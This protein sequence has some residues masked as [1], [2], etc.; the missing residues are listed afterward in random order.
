MPNS[1]S[2]VTKYLPELDKVYQY[3]S[4]SA[5]L[6]TPAAMVRETGDARTI[7][8]AKMSM[9]GM[10]DYDR[11]AGY[12]SG[13]VTLDWETHTFSQDRARSFEVDAMDDEESFQ[14]SFGMLSGEFI[15]T[16]EV[17]DTDA[18]RFA[19]Y[20]S[21]AITNSNAATADLSTGAGVISALRTAT[22]AMD[23]AEV[24]EEGRILFI[25]PTNI[26]YVDDL[27]TTKSK[28]VLGRFS[29]IIRVPQARFY[30]AITQYDG[31]TYGQE[32]G[33]YIKNASTGKNINFLVVYPG[34]IALQAIKRKVDKVIRPE[35]NQTSDS[36]KYFFRKY[37]DAFVY[38][39]KVDGLYC[40]Y[41]TS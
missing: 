9:Q 17:P 38:E 10:G 41:A 24:P 21:N 34:A 7:K 3:A 14:M 31:S 11:T 22:N 12:P 2:L 33:G 18:Y 30:T 15:R 32:D 6:D 4:K 26:S 25:T 36:W 23:E 37:H 35:D 20:A 29:Q 1:I 27:D 16:K 28:A 8:F 13:T 39:N 19:T 40:H 5:V